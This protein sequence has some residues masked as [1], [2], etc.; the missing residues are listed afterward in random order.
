MAVD[1]DCIFTFRVAIDEFFE[2]VRAERYVA[3]KC[4]RNVTVQNVLN[5]A[6]LVV[7]F[8]DGVATATATT[9]LGNGGLHRWYH[10]E[11]MVE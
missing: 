7:L 11:W 10:G 9:G 3:G 4:G 1:C 5:D 8:A 6:G 2:V